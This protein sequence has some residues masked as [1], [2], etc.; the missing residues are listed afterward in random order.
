M[1]IDAQDGRV[2]HMPLAQEKNDPTANRSLIA[3]RKLETFKVQPMG[4]KIVMISSCDALEAP[5]AM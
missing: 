4:N 5:M 1:P 3:V 2:A